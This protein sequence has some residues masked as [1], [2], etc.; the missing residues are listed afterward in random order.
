MNEIDHLYWEDDEFE[1]TKRSKS[2]TQDHAPSLRFWEKGC[3]HWRQPFELE[4]G[5]VVFASSWWDRPDRAKYSSPPGFSGQPDIGFYLDSSWGAST[6]LVSAGF[7]P[8][9]VKRKSADPKIILHPWRDW[10]TPE[11]PRELRSALKWL[12][13]EARRGSIIDIGCMGGHGRTG[14]ALAA[15]LVLQGLDSGTAIRRVRIDYCDEA[16]ESKAQ[17]R[18]I[19][20]FGRRGCSSN[21]RTPSS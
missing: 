12:L 13:R 18:F 4:D 8:P 20:S 3:R 14:T 1:P 7:V 6:I 21:R 15:L 5:L 11:N 2:P 16:I 17:T 10:G 9:Y 19:R